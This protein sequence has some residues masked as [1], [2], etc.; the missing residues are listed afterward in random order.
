MLHDDFLWVEKYRPKTVEDTILPKELKAVFQTFVDQN[1]IPNLMLTGKP[2]TG[3]T[4]VARAMLEQI[5]CDY[6]LIN[7]SMN[8][9]IDTLRYDI[10]NFATSISFG[11][12]RKYVILDEADYLNQNST[13]PALRS[14][15]EEFSQNCG[16]IL[17][18]NFPNRVIP[19]LQSRCSVIDFKIGPKDRPK[20][21]SQF[22][23]RV[24]HILTEENVPF[25]EPVIAQLIMKYFPDWRRVINEL[26]RYAATGSIDTGILAN[27]KEI[28]LTE[29]V[30]HL[31]SKDFTAVRKWVVDNANNDSQVFFRALYD[32]LA[33]S[34]QT[35]S[36]PQLVIIIGDYQYKA[37]FVADQE[38]NIAACLAEIAASCSFK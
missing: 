28:S 9:N 15:M 20:L 34:L 14:F 33:D 10:Q 2:G 19:A 38:I 12:G 31:K 27:F 18:C 25:E 16:F 5:G 30:E 17:T 21:A 36:V 4:T 13:Q 7:S 26:Q 6:I 11:G 24:T 37:A 23:K 1:N 8:G 32:K 35:S 22:M 29:L 3:K